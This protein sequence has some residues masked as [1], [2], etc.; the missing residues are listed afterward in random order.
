MDQ[1]WTDTRLRPRGQAP[2]DE[3]WTASTWTHQQA[4]AHVKERWCWL[5]SRRRLDQLSQGGHASI[6]CSSGHGWAGHAST[7]WRRRNCYMSTSWFGGFALKIAGG[8]FV[9]WGLKT[10]EWWVGGQ[11]LASRSLLQGE[12]KSWRCRDRRMR[13]E[14][15]GQL[16]PFVWVCI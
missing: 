14:S 16:C 7:S 4:S 12:A 11:V 6:W 5:K 2:K 9:D 8:K 15:F 3:P 13:E 10:R 1:K